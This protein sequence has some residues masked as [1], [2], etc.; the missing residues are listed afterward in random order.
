MSR[1][2]AKFAQLRSEGKK[3]FVA[4]VMAGDPDYETGLELVKGLPG[5]GV[6]IIELGMPFTD[7]MADGTTIQLAGQRALEGG[8]TLEKT[9]EYAR[10]LRQTDDVTPIVMMGYYNPIYSRGV[11]AFLADAV[12]A[13]ID[14]LIIVDLPPEEDD[15]LCIPAQKAGINFIRLATPTTDDKRL[16]KVLENT[17]GFVYYVSVTGITG[18]AEAQTADV[19]P[20]V[21]RIKAQ[22]DLPVIV[23]FGIKTPEAA[24]AIAEIAD[25][26]VVGSAIVAKIGAGDSVDDVLAFVKS[27]ADGTHRA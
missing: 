22:T 27:L 11:D 17:S 3:A 10:A 8:Q 20:E 13:G 23:G 9:L 25:G 5:A 18:T 15:E 6:D 12:A 26:A 2:D 24:Q 7:P 14:G 21:A 16:P 19:A 4:Y 1:I